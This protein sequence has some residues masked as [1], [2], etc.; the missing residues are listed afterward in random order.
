MRMNYYIEYCKRGTADAHP[1]DGFRYFFSKGP[2]KFKHLSSVIRWTLS[3]II[4]LQYKV[5]RSNCFCSRVTCENEGGAMQVAPQTQGG[6]SF[7]CQFLVNIIGEIG[8]LYRL[9]VCVCVQIHEILRSACLTA[10]PIPNCHEGDALAKRRK[11]C[12]VCCDGAGSLP[13]RNMISEEVCKVFRC[14]TTRIRGLDT[15]KWKI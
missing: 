5:V 11:P 2:A 8:V 4:G 13:T 12:P 6:V 14:C 10:S 15:R 3:T 1:S 7:S 9:T